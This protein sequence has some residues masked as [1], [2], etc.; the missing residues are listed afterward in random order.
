M[1]ANR[2][3]RKSKMIVIPTIKEVLV[4]VPK[5]HHNKNNGKGFGF[6]TQAHKFIKKIYGQLTLERIKH[7][8]ESEK[9]FNYIG[10]MKKLNHGVYFKRTKTL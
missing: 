7:I 3:T 4:S 8:P 1:K 9:S 10:R 2:K 6:I 5:M